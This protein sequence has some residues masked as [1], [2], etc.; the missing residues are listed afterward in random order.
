MK[1]MKLL[2]GMVLAV[3]LAFSAGYGALSAFA[4]TQAAEENT[5]VS[6]DE[7]FDGLLD[8]DFD[9]SSVLVTM[10]EEVSEV[11]KKY[12]KSYFGDIEISSIEDLSAMTGNI[13]EKKYFDESKFRQ[14]LQ[15]NLPEK[16]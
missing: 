11:N 14:I 3:A 15:L 10:T 13:A 8:E 12:D 5:A 2:A 6:L 16:G 4:E 7:D 9:G 1:R